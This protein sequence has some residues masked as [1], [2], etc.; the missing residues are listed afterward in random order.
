MT[1][2]LINKNRKIRLYIRTDANQALGMGHLVRCMALAQSVEGL[3]TP[4]FLLKD[5]PA[6][7]TQMLEEAGFEW[8]ALPPMPVSQEPQHLNELMG[9]RMA[10]LVADGYHFDTAWW[11]NMQ[12]PNRRLIAIDDEYKLML[13]VDAVINHAPGAKPHLYKVPAH[14]RLALGPAYALLRPAFLQ[15]AQG[16]GKTSA[17][18]ETGAKGTP[19]PP[20]QPVSQPQGRNAATAAPQLLRSKQEVFI[21]FGGSDAHNHSQQVAQILMDLPGIQVLHLVAGA[22][23]PHLEAWHEWAAEHNRQARQAKQQQSQQNGQSSQPN[24]QLPL[25]QIHQNLSAQNMASLMARCSLAVAPASGTAMELCACRVPLICGYT[26]TNQTGI[27]EGLSSLGMAAPYGNFDHLD[28]QRLL[29]LATTLQEYSAAAQQMAN[30]AHHLSGHTGRRLGKLLQSLAR[31]LGL[32][33]HRATEEDLM[34]YFVWANDPALRANS[35][36]QQAISL[37]NHKEWFMRRLKDPNTCFY[38]FMNGSKPVGQVRFD[39]K[40]EGTYINY[41]IAKEHRG[42]GLSQPILR[43]AMRQLEVD[44]CRGRLPGWGKMQITPDDYEVTTS[45]LHHTKGSQ[46][47]GATHAPHPEMQ[48]LPHVCGWPRRLVYLALVKP[49]NEAS[50]KAFVANNYTFAENRTISGMPFALYRK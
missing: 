34:L 11:V 40:E 15:L 27:F 16:W 10:L 2:P 41:S 46:H 43:L 14:T 36:N 7:V 9:R 32:Q 21:S 30:Q 17:A 25:I 13:P 28:P 47:P 33:V 42:K 29:A 37:E 20:H 8:H 35:I 23:N 45:S 5:P 18:P 26:A 22:T 50:I 19:E 12:H 38:L 44:V 4:L 48:N 31:E 1:N 49:E 6:S 39:H 3:F 24:G